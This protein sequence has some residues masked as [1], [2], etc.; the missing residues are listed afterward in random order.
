MVI[1]IKVS[2]SGFSRV[3]SRDIIEKKSVFDKGIFGHFGF[4]LGIQ[5]FQNTMIFPKSV[6]DGSNVIFGISV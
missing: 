1:D 6:I 2:T 3:D 5:S 4:V